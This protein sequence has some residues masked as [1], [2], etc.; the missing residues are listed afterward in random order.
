MWCGVVW[1]GVSGDLCL[2][3]DYVST[4]RRTAQHSTFS[5]VQYSASQCDDVMSLS[6]LFHSSTWYVVRGRVEEKRMG[7]LR[8][9]G[10]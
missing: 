9:K 6:F 1:C 4:D 5:T 7:I 8:W 10:E 2:L 3:F